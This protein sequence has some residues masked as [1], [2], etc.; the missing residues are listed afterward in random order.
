MKNSAMRS[1]A[2]TG[3]KTIESK[4]GEMVRITPEKLEEL[5]NAKSLKD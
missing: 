4:T 1:A 5:R 3:D 2:K